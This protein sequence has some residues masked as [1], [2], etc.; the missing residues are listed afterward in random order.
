MNKIAIFK[1]NVVL[2]YVCYLDLIVTIILLLHGNHEA[3]PIMSFF[4]N[5]GIEWFVIVKFASVLPFVIA[6]EHLGRKEPQKARR[7]IKLA[8]GIYLVMY[9][10]LFLKVNWLGGGI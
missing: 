4:Y 2:L 10:I 1:E 9:V 3:N 5:R 6:T 8:I 7:Y